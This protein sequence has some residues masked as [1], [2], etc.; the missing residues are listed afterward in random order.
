MVNSISSLAVLC[1]TFIG[2]QQQKVFA[3]FYKKKRLKTKKY[4][5]KNYKPKM[6]MHFAVSMQRTL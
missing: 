4:E 1:L 6:L 2:N 5:V 3:L